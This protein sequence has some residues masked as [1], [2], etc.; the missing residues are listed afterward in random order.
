MPFGPVCR[1]PGAP[2]WAARAV[3]RRLLVVSLAA[4]AVLAAWATPA[5]GQVDPPSPSTTDTSSPTTST[6]VP[7]STTST[8]SPDT[9]VPPEGST[10]TLPPE[11]TTT[12]Q[13][14]PPGAPVTPDALAQLKELTS[15]LSDLTDA[16][17]ALLDNYIAILQKLLDTGVQINLINTSITTAQNEL[18]QAQ[19]R[20]DRAEASLRDIQRQLDDVDRQLADQQRMLR[21]HA[22]ASYI[23]GGNRLSVTDALLKGRNADEFGVTKAYAGAVRADGDSIVA[24]YQRTRAE[25][26]RLRDRAAAERNAAVAARDAKSSIEAQ[27]EQQRDQQLQLAIEAQQAALEQQ[28][29][30]ELAGLQRSA[31]EQRIAELTAS[32][33]SIGATLKQR[34]A[35]QVLPAIT[36]GI[37]SHPIP[38]AIMTSPFGPRLHP[39][40]G[41]V[42]MHNGVDF[43][44][45][46][47]Q[48]MRAAADGQVVIAS[49][50][51]GYGN[52]VVIDHGNGIATLY[53][54]L[55]AY[56]VQ[57]GD[58]VRR[59]QPVGF[60]GSTGASTGPH[61]HFEVRIFGDPVNPLPYLG[62]G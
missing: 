54:H 19:Q 6:S 51:G 1:R 3:R 5:P 25:A 8:I 16:E 11:S 34:Q 49:T 2:V 60:A 12:S 45:A 53:A 61:L 36:T 52:C 57:V 32:S 55:T 43:D 35:G 31:Y 28:G 40:Y 14:L 9:T 23:A 17:K 30:L 21:E 47:G 44:A 39:I 37:L 58:Q 42:K 59:G 4:V 15:Q 22:V 48:P 46:I 27:L 62:P 38:N 7:D 41:I 33:G 56:A 10:T 26:Q 29:L 13:V 20:V 18:A 50:Q 24:R